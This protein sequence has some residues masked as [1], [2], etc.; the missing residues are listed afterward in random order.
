MKWSRNSFG[1]G[2]LQLYVFEDNSWKHYRVSK[3]YI[4]DEAVSSNSGFATAQVYMR[5]GYT[6]LDNTENTSRVA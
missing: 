4:A 2:Q 6:Y 1:Q 5:Y 3:R